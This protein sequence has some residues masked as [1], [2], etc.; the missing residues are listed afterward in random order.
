MKLLVTSVRNE[1]DYLVEW[2]A[3][4]KLVGFDHF[5]IYTNNNTDSTVE[6]LHALKDIGLVS[7]FEL[8]PG[9]DKKPQ[10]FAFN[11]ALAWMKSQ[12]PRWVSCMDV[13]EFLNL[14]YDDNIDQFISRLN[15]PDAI[16]INWKIYGTS[17]LKGRGYGLTPERFCW[18]ANDDYRQHSQFKT[19][20]KYSGDIV[21]FHHRVIYPLKKQQELRYVYSDGRALP[22]AMKHSGAPFTKESHITFEYA[23]IN[24]YATRSLNELSAKMMRGNGLE[25]VGRENARMKEYLQR[26]DKGDVYDNTILR[27]I[28]EFTTEYVS[29][30]EDVRLITGLCHIR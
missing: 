24:H 3:W 30:L 20:W 26:F 19:L 22:P 17:G 10:M 7:F 21:R 29:L 2:I 15:T 11:Q 18:C 13:D 16:A 8:N 25:P 9:P 4:H 6:I 23:Q 1:A 28:D 12:N 27:R 14:K 5:L